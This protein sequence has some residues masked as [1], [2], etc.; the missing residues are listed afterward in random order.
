M[1]S[2]RKPSTRTIA[3]AAFT[4]LTFV[5][6][7]FA[8]TAFPHVVHAQGI[9]ANEVLDQQVGET[10]GTGTE[11]LRIVIARLIR[12]AF[13]FLGIIAVVL[14]LYAGFLWMTA[15]GEEDKVNRAKRT[16]TAA[17]IG[18]VIMLSAFG[19]TS[20]IISRLLGEGG[21]FGG[22]GTVESSSAND[23][24]C[25]GL[26]ATCPAG[27]L[28]NGIIEGH[29]PA[30][31]AT[32]IARNTRVVVTFKEAIDPASIVLG[33]PN[34]TMAI[35]RSSQVVGT[36][37]QFADKFAQ[38][39][40]GAD[41]DIAPT[42]DGRTF[43]FIQ[44]NCPA[45]CFGSPS[46]NVFYTVALR[47][48]ADG[49]KKAS[50]SPAF[51]GTFNSGYLWE[52][53][54][55]TVLDLTPPRVSYTIPVDGEGNVPRNSMVQV[56]FNEAVDPVSV[57]SGV[58]VSGPGGAVIAGVQAIGN[59][60]RSVEFRT[61]EVCGTNSC[62]EQVYC[63]PGNKH[64]SVAVKSDGL[65]ATP[66]T[67]IFPPNGVTDMAGNSLDGNGNGTAEGPTGDDYGFAFDTSNAIDLVPPKVVSQ[68]PAILQ[69]EIPRD[70]RMTATFSKLMS[71]TSMTTSSVR[72]VPGANG[73]PTNYWI[74][75]ES[76]SSVAGG[77]PDQGQAQIHHD[78]LS[79]NQPYAAS[80]TSGLRDLRQNCFYPGAGQTVCTGSEPFCCNG[81][82]SQVACGFIQ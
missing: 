20:F 82:A 50:G 64:I 38:S 52:F 18:L 26:S 70:M 4:V 59:S 35:L 72:L 32:G 62:G 22:G 74:D 81:V 41:I 3:T 10:I 43:V 9:T 75:G 45:D 14:I 15:A 63:L 77:Q 46:E 6:A 57:A 78:L 60:Y 53:Q 29:F 66:P 39:L 27:A 8:Y 21:L 48:G 33:G 13:G 24:A 1:L 47:G 28:G 49:V 69:G 68:D 17:I 42:E 61:N 36:S 54:V 34:P 76:V 12:A 80:L 37:N 25:I 23:R 55:S 71:L 19:I 65:T 58:S 67:G 56:T 40:G 51:S 79:T 2:G 16:L 5:L 11:D 30:R 7:A 31:N 44:K 73:A